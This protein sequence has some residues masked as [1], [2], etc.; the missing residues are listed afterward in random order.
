MT[1][2]ECEARP[3]TADGQQW[4]SMTPWHDSELMTPGS[5]TRQLYLEA[6][7]ARARRN[8]PPMVLTV[9]PVIGRG[10]FEKAPDEIS[11]CVPVYDRPRR[12]R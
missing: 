10:Q 6:L 9:R 11:A 5:R 12:R 2:L 3:K 8:P 1:V 7:R 4:V